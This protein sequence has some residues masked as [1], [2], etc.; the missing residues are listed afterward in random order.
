[1]AE[2]E[3]EASQKPTITGLARRLGQL[4]VEKKRAA[5]EISA[6]LAG[7]SLRVSREFVEAVPKAAKILSADDLRHWGEMGRRLAMGNADIGAKFFT[8]GVSGLKKVPEPARSAVFQVCTRQL[9]LSS[10]ISLETFQLIPDLAGEIGDDKLLSE[11][12][13]L[14]VEIAQRSAKHSS[15]FLRNTP[16][17]AHALAKFENEKDKVSAA[18]LALAAQFAERTGGMTADL[19][20]N[21]P[22]ALEKISADEAVLLMDRASE[23]LEFG[24]SVTLHF[25]SAGSEVLA[26]TPKAFDD[27]HLLARSIAKHGNAVLI[28]FLRTTPKFFGSFTKKKKAK[29]ED[30][31][32]VLQL[33]AKI[34]ETD[35]ESALA[36]FR[37]SATALKTVSIAQFE[38]WVENGIR[39]REH[40]STKARR[41]YFALETRDSNER[42][43]ETRLG[44]PLERIQT[45]LRMY[46]EALTGKEIEVA[47][48]SAGGQESRIGDG[49]TIYLPSAV[50]EFDDDEM[51]FRLYKVLAAH[52]AG[53]IEFG[54]F[55]QDTLGLKAAYADLIDLYSATAD[56]L[57]AFSLAG[58][59]EDVQKGEKALPDG[60]TEKKRS[61]KLPKNSD[62]RTVLTAF[63]EPRLA[64]KIFAT[65]ENA[66]I[67]T[68]LRHT[69]RGLRKDLD[70]MQSHLNANRPYIFD[71]PMHQVPFE[72]LFQITLCGGATDDAKR[73]YGQIV[74]EI[75]SVMEK[76]LQMNDATVADSLMATSRVY[77]LFQNIT[78]EDSQEAE[79]DN[80]EDKSEF[81]YDDKD[82]AEAVTEDQVKREKQKNTDDIRDLFNAWNS[83]DDE[84]EPDDLQGSEAWSQS[85]IPEQALEVDD[86]AFAYDEW[87]RDLN[88][89]RVGWSRV[90]EKKV[91]QGDRNFVEL[92]R[93]RYRGVISS[94]R[95]QFQLMKPE[96]LTRVNR[97]IDGEDYDLNALVDFV[98]D[99]RA[100][101][102]QSEN[103]YTKKLRRQRDVAVSILLDQSS[104][105]ARTITRNPLQPYT[106]PGRRIIEIEKEGLV[107]MSEALE[108][109]GDVYSIYGFTS[110]GRRNVKFYVVKDFAEK[111]SEVIEKRIGGI[112][113]QNNTRLGAAIRHASHKL[114]RQ[115][116]R[117]K[118]LI[119]LTDGRP[120]DHDYGDARYA[121]EDVREALTEAKT[122]GITPFCITI[123]R[124]SEAELKDL[125]GNV[126]YT[127]IDDVLS[128]PE[129]M[130]NIYRRLTS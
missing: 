57:D 20:A 90:I 91:K 120:Y 33:T 53:Q 8:D 123:D 124:E 122:T 71:L 72:L 119:I 30:I 15:E 4:S 104:S 25:V 94:I 129:R 2:N 109:V 102:L 35:A 23:F 40:D 19:W 44:L 24:G 89:Y 69:Y 49:K 121:R 70:L 14:A 97:E 34:A 92:T 88:D 48:I 65:M 79:S 41:S 32:R 38:E 117:T 95:H 98:V 66:R 6:A 81:A 84:G 75:E 56:Q 110:E 27:W 16:E 114:L 116:A 63:P 58:Y 128:L 99:R 100:D 77:T 68:R 86:V 118:L 12:L 28:S 115:E 45:V 55:E 85:D 108:A 9:V 106:H 130:P 21:L 42:L 73:F 60:V 127:I 78:P 87:D 22:S 76:H 82:A 54:T 52:G 107:L 59:I 43:Q 64:R 83:L 67:D 10:S 51:D 46:I 101:G 1:M 96:N 26:S 37:S 13:L 105:T 39:E 31:Q 7:V 61:P 111:Y 113:F 112:T 125:Y 93:S 29:P 103:I 11:I 126:G 36:A 18:I 80:T 74:S 62:Y 5:L 47:P 17:V 50:A 3:T